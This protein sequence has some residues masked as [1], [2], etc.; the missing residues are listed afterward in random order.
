MNV[1][2]RQFQFQK[3]ITTEKHLNTLLYVQNKTVEFS[4]ENK[5]EIHL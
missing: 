2:S 4:D 1:K 3:T 5:M